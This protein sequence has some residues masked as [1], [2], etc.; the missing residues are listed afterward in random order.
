MYK[1]TLRSVREAR[2]YT[3]GAVAA[4]LGIPKS[5]YS[6]YEVNPGDAQLSIMLKITS[7]LKIPMIAIY[8][9]HEDDCTNHNKYNLGPHSDHA[10]K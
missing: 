4:Q 7:L 9:G 3:R 2:G 1:V 5:V 10:I 8:P 6:S